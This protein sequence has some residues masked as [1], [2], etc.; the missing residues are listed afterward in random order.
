MS[1][2]IQKNNVGTVFR[3]TFKDCDGVVIDISSASTKNMIF[4]SPSGVSSTKAGAFTTDGS[5]GQLDYTSEAD[6]LNEAGTWSVQGHVIIGAQNFKSD[7]STF[8][9]IDNL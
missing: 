1:C 5:N 9:V 6:F 4:A 7:I 8:T 3:M 2:S